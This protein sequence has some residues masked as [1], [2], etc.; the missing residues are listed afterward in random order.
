M[1]Q[2]KF[3]CLRHL[4]NEKNIH[5]LT[6]QNIF[7]F[8]LIKYFWTNGEKVFFSIKLISTDR[9]RLYIDN[10]EEILRKYFIRRLYNWIS[11]DCIWT[12]GMQCDPILTIMIIDSSKFNFEVNLY[13]YERNIVDLFGAQIKSNSHFHLHQCN[14]SY[15]SST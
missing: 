1:Y 13:N 7:L 11:S 6:R 3:Y 12:R 8:L 14:S 9:E 4:K 2:W 5:V 10:R 15:F